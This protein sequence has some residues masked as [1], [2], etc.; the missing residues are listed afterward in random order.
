MKQRQKLARNPSEVDS[1]TNELRKF[2]VASGLPTLHECRQELDGYV[3]VLKGQDPSP[4]TNGVLSL[5]EVANAYLSR[6]LE[7]TMVIQRGE[8]DGSIVKGS[9]F[10]KF[11]TGE[12]RTFT[13]L[14]SKAADLGS[15]RVTVAQ[16]EYEMKERVV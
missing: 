3:R 13:E 4:I 16:M 2:R 15:R 8:S 6:A 10:Y 11:R 9:H 1:E 14:A 5:M 12:L 7:L